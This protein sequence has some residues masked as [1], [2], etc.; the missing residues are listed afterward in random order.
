MAIA[1]A[2]ASEAL[3]AYNTLQCSCF[4]GTGTA[5]AGSTL[6]GELGGLTLFP[7]TYTNA[8]TVDITTGDL[9]L[10]A[11]GD[12]NAYWVFQVG[13]ALTVGEAGFPRNVILA[14]GAQASHIFWAV[15]TSATINGAGGGTFEGTIIAYYS[16]AVSTAENVNPVIVNGRLISLNASTTLVD[17]VINVPPAP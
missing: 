15:A 3:T 6:A 5:P 12:T 11:Q 2:A 8:S 16:I 1:T 17:T 7:G 4:P 13:S 14:H 10:D 9:T